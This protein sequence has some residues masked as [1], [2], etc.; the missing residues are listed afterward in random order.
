MY[1]GKAKEYDQNQLQSCLKMLTELD[2]YL[3][4]HK[5]AAAD[6]VTLADLAILTMVASCKVNILDLHLRFYK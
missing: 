6:Y 4:E 1:D 5:W 2:I 3:G